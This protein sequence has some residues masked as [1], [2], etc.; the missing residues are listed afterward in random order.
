MRSINIR[1][2]IY[3]INVNEIWVPR[4]LSHL[5]GGPFEITTNLCKTTRVVLPK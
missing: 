4:V 1:T 5:T 3:F 2:Y